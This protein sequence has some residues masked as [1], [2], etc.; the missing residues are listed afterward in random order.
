VLVEFTCDSLAQALGFD[1]EQ[2]R[3]P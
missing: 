3:I 1:Y 2:R